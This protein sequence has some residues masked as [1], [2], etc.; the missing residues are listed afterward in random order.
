[1]DRWIP[2]AEVPIKQAVVQDTLLPKIFSNFVKRL[3][4]KVTSEY[5]L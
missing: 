1:M 3:G 5:L 2:E 4:P